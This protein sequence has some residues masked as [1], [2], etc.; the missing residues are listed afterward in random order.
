[1]LL[2]IK[3]MG[4]QRDTVRTEQLP[5]N[6]LLGYVPLTPGVAELVPLS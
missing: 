6:G 2:A 5:L 3:W 1:M 4:P